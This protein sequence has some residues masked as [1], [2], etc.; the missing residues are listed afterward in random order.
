MV[1]Q[2]LHV[3]GQ[4][5]RIE[6]FD[7]TDDPGVQGLAPF[8]EQRAVGD[9]MGE[10][11]LEGVFGIGKEPRLVEKLGRLQ[12]REPRC[13]ASSVSSATAWSS[14]KGT[15][16]PMTEAVWSSCLSS[17]GSRSIRAARITCTVAGTSIAWIGRVRR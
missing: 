14:T 16:L 4:P 11:V 13:T 9:F 10:R 1:S 3:L 7:G 6:A 12:M 8:L 17:A 15:S 2:P 5:V